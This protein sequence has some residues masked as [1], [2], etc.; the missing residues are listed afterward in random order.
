MR[1]ANL[2]IS[3]PKRIF[4]LAQST[5]LF[6]RRP[7][8]GHLSPPK[9]GLPRGAG[10]DLRVDYFGRGTGAGLAVPA[11][12]RRLQPGNLFEC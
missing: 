4:A 6:D 11:Q 2:A 12:V 1:R 10:A 9:P 3:D 8:P 5:V 7:F